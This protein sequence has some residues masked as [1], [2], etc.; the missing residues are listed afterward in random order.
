MAKDRSQDTNRVSKHEESREDYFGRKF[1]Y[2]LANPK[3]DNYEDQKQAAG[4]KMAEE[5]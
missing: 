2:E 1:G 5:N 4:R 3:A